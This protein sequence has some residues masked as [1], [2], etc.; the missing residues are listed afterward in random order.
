[1]KKMLFLFFVI[2]P[3]FIFAADDISNTDI[4]PR[5]VNFLI[6]AAIIYYLLAD[7]INNFLSERTISIQ[8]E[9]DEVQQ[10]LEESKKKVDEAKAELENAKQIAS[11][12]VRE[13][14][15]DVENIKAKVATSYENDIAYLSKSF[16]DKME[17]E[18][19]T[20]KKE[21]VNE[22]LEELMNKE[23]VAISQENLTSIILKKV[24]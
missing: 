24:A 3:V 17:L 18:I 8:A 1:M 21:V 10:T 11:N 5:T 19:K 6:F 23:N 7:K 12:L 9:L 16:D 15:A 2:F 20:A 13:A 22:V 4:V 14:Q